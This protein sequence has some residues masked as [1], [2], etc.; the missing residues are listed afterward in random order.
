LQTQ[1]GITL[2]TLR[3]IQCFLDKY[4]GRLADVVRSGSRR[5]LDQAVTDLA[6]LATSQ[7]TNATAAS[8]VEKSRQIR[9]NLIEKHMLPIA[10]IAAVDLPRTPELA[11]LLIPRGSPTAEKLVQ[12]AHAMRKTAT[13]FAQTFIE[14]GMPPAFLD[15]LE[16]AANA[17]AA[18]SAQRKGSVGVG[19]AATRG[20][21][22]TISRGS[23]VITAIDGLVRKVLDPND[24]NDQRIRTEWA[25]V[26]KVRRAASR[27]ATPLEPVPIPP[28]PGASA[29]ATGGEA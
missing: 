12:A 1:Q 7:A 25:S 18:F 11:K 16:D 28:A 15:E 27:A 20:I 23:R 4:A 8:G 3:A 9:T 13:P 26:K 10:R 2:E 29:P 6:D 24:P 19:K 21:K 5:Q 14:A 22:D 17:L